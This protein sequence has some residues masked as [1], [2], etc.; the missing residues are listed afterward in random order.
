MANLRKE[1]RRQLAKELIICKTPRA[2]IIHELTT[3]FEITRRTAERDLSDL[4]ES[5]S[6]QTIAAHELTTLGLA[7]CEAIRAGDPKAEAKFR[8]QAD[9]IFKE[10]PAWRVKP[11]GNFYFRLHF[12]FCVFRDPENF[13]IID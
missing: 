12:N 11:P 9:V 6:P 2:K 1:Q 3:K 4:S 10:Y 5:I 13:K 8:K 7:C